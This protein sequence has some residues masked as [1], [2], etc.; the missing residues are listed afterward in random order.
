MKIL[1]SENK[2]LWQR[3]NLFVVLFSKFHEGYIN[4]VYKSSIKRADR[5]LIVDDLLAT[6]T[7]STQLTFGS[8]ELLHVRNVNLTLLQEN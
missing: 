3:L 6:G 8:R 5:V 7:V 2:E 4:H 1:G